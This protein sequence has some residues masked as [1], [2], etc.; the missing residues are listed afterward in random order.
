MRERKILFHLNPNAGKPISFQIIEQVRWMVLTGLLKPGDQLPTV[1]ALAEH[2]GVNPNTI[3]KTY[4]RLK[5]K[6]IVKAVPGM[7]VYI[8]ENARENAAAE[9]VATLRSHLRGASFSALTM[10]I[11]YEEVIQI[12]KEEWEICQ[13]E[14]KH[15]GWEV[16]N[17]SE[18]ERLRKTTQP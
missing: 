1:K 13:K 17:L 14:M 5:D 12:L 15:S 18:D 7:G 8:A 2:L 3:A 10:G 11:R 4:T 16:R 6:N 9:P